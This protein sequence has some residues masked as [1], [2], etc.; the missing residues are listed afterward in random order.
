MEHIEKPC[1]YY[2]SL[3]LDCIDERNSPAMHM[4]LR[5]HMETCSACRN[6]WRE[7]EALDTMARESMAIEAPV[8]LLPGI[9]EELSHL[10]ERRHAAR[11]LTLWWMAMKRRAPLYGLPTVTLVL[12]LVL[13]CLAA[14]EIPVSTTAGTLQIVEFFTGTLAGITGVFDGISSYLQQGALHFLRE[15]NGLEKYLAPLQRATFQGWWYALA[16]LACMA[17]VNYA[18]ISQKKEGGDSS[19]GI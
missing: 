12:A 19:W 1:S 11:P 6:A 3:I 18:L 13:Y 14:R 17:P 10:E 15:M 5:L 9:M 8:E 4:E 2:E 16:V 7:Y